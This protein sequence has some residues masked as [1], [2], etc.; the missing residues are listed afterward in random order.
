MADILLHNQMIEQ[1]DAHKAASSNIDYTG[2]L[3]SSLKVYI[4]AI[5]DANTT[6]TAPY[7]QGGGGTPTRKLCDLTQH[8]LISMCT[9]NYAGSSQTMNTS[10]CNMT[11][12]WNDGSV[13]SGSSVSERSIAQIRADI[14]A[15][16]TTGTL[17][18]M[19]AVNNAVVQSDIYVAYLQLRIDYN[20]AS[21]VNV[22]KNWYN[23][24][25]SGGGFSEKQGQRLSDTNYVKICCPNWQYGEGPASTT[26]AVPAGA[27]C[28]KFQVW[29]AGY[30]TNG[31][32]CCGGNQFGHNGAYTEA[33][34][35]VTPGDTYTVCAGCSCQRYCC[36]NSTPGEGCASGVTG[37]GICC[38]YAE[39]GHCYNGNCYEQNRMRI[40]CSGFAGGECRRVQNPYCTTSGPC[41]CNY[42]EYCFDN[43]CSTCGVLPV[44]PGCCWTKYCSCITTACCVT[45]QSDSCRGHF[46]I[47]GGACLDSNNYGY[48]TRP[49]II[50]ADTGNL[51]SQSCGCN[52][53][54]FTSGGCC[55]GCA[56]RNWNTHPGH[57]G[58]GTH[59]MGGQTNHFGDTG[60]SG[61]VQISWIT[62]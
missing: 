25:I 15:L 5:I 57:G 31:A 45:D 2:P 6:T 38:L 48:H 32:C 52:V 47:Y 21:N 11:N 8:C 37:N 41:Y 43:S 42:S 40:N 60:R 27:T 10:T 14:L 33:V 22:M 24:D 61:M 4:K 56:G 55:G 9:C 50:N 18:K 59:V 7:Y 1:A 3:G 54:T 12:P 23:V 35:K 19:Y 30:G 16:D 46:G 34:M 17:D 62:S 51:W 39:G 29:G 44:Y 58:A 53:Q 28:A 20:T 26:W 13:F 36:S 49:P